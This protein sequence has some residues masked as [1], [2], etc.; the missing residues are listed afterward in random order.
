M[1]K[2][3][4]QNKVTFVSF[5]TLIP[6]PRSYPAVVQ[7]GKNR[8]ALKSLELK[9]LPGKH[10]SMYCYKNLIILTMLLLVTSTILINYQQCQ[11]FSHKITS[12]C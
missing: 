10:L 11:M 9:S 5:G 12:L 2:N 6:V 4:W 7:G 1:L 8:A 3:G